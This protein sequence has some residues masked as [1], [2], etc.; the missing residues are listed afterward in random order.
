MRIPI[1]TP[2][3]P[4]GDIDY[5]PPPTFP[6]GPFTKYK[7]NPILQPDPA[8]EF[9]EAYLYNP[10]AI[11]VDDKVFL[12]YRAQNRAKTLTVGIA[13]L[14]DG[15]HFTRHVRPV[16]WPTELWEQGGGCEDPRVVRDPAL[17]KF[18]MTYTAYDR[19]TAR[20][21]VAESTDLFH[22]TKHPPFIPGSFEEICTGTDGKQY[23]R[24][25]WLKSGAVFT[26]RHTDG[27][28]YMIW[29]ESGLYLAWSTDLVEWHAAGGGRDAVFAEGHYPWQ[30]R[31]I[32][33]GPPPIRLAGDRNLYVFFYNSCTRGGGPF[34]KGTYL[35]AQ[36]LIDYDNVRAGPL[37]RTE[38]P[39]LVP[40]AHNEVLGQVN[41]VVFCAGVVQFHGQ[42]FLYFGQGDLELGV[43]TAPL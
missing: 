18:I 19:R 43:A 16:L 27:R 33:P 25:G 36:M 23:I 17:K 22:W 4:D 38:R 6:L 41:R 40:E 21:C 11:V 31:L 3:T 2:D 9:E 32:E 24:H 15:L 13:W 26:E 34:E 14:T 1:I 39:F 8:H 20:L 35:V 37:A 10:T 7:G 5:T 28:Y 42:W 30:N 29:G 12:L